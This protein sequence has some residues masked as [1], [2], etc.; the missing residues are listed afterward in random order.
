MRLLLLFSLIA[1]L[2][3]AAETVVATRTIRAQEIIG[4]DAVRGDAGGNTG[5]KLDDIIGMEARVALY[6][7]RPI[8]TAHVMPPALIA[9]NQIVEL[10]FETGGL[11]ITSEARALDRGAVGE[12]IRV[13]NIASHVNLFGTVSPDGSVHVSQ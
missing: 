8:L 10:V 9:R 12:R 6:P 7:G 3:A 1:G 13:M 11:R 2:P 5:V 4:P